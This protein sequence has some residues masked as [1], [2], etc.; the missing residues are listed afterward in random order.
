MPITTIA[1]STRIS[2]Y[3][4]RPWPSS[5]VKKLRSIGGLLIWLCVLFKVKTPDA[6]GGCAP[7]DNSSVIVGSFDRLQH[8][9]CCPIAKEHLTCLPEVGDTRA[10]DCTPIIP[11]KKCQ[12]CY[13]VLMFPVLE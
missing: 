13:V 4:T 6:E 1:I 8:H 5:L 10:D 7:T 11:I 9:L 2:A 12:N 3:S